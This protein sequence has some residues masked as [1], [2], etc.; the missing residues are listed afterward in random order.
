MF[1]SYISYA[2]LIT[3]VHNPYL[4]LKKSKTYRV[5]VHTGNHYTCIHNLMNN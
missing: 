5:F 2:L 1:E 4:I 3:H